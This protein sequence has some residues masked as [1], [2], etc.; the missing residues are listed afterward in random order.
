MLAL[1]RKTGE[2]IVIG[3]NIEL[4]ILAISKDQVKVGI[5][6]PKNISIHRKEIYLQ[7]KEENQQ[8][9]NPSIEALDKMKN[10]L[11]KD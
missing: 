11:K 4:T 1:T 8:A 3:D 6:A 9:S 10:I 2:T 7:I 5:D